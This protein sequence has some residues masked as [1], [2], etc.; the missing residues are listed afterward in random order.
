[1]KTASRA[2]WT[3]VAF[4]TLCPSVLTAET[5]DIS[6]SDDATQLTIGAHGAADG[7]T[8]SRSDIVA[9]AD[10]AELEGGPAFNTQVRVGLDLNLR[11]DVGKL[12]II[13]YTA[14]GADVFSGYVQDNSSIEGIDL[15]G[16]ETHK[17]VVREAFARVSIGPI[18]TVGGG[19]MT[20]QWGLGLL[21]NSGEE[22]WKPGSA[23]FVDPRGGDV[24]L[25][26]LLATGPWTDARLTVYGFADR[27]R[28]DRSLRPGDEATQFGGGARLGGED[29]NVGIYFVRREVTALD[30]DELNVNAIDVAGGYLI[31]LDETH[32]LELEGEVALISGKADFGPNVDFPTHDV[33][34]LGGAVR[35]TFA[36]SGWGAVLDAIWA[37]GD[38]NLDDAQINNFRADPNY[39]MGLLLFREVMATQSG[40]APV[41]ASNPE[42]VG[43]PADDLDRLPTQG[44]VTNTLAFF[45]R[46]Y[47]QPL[48]G[49]ELYG[50]PLFAFADSAVVDPLNTRLNG[51]EPHNALG[52]TGGRFLGTELD[53]GARAHLD[54]PR[55]QMLSAGIEAAVLLPGNA[56]RDAAGDLMDPVFGGRAMARYQF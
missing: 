19:I 44:S 50:G 23:A 31:E 39:E 30:G 52:G 16:S 36:A 48:K 6:S 17:N 45:P 54:L 26:G 3:T 32:D 41:T 20:S 34:Q 13:V 46:A 43:E 56:F 47:W 18:I 1:M 9:D 22:T 5:Y 33:L 27:V 51:G 14:V 4:I 42:L 11:Q 38:Q 40:R 37:S 8:E 35:G 7:R 2:W 28:E 53:L 12:P 10:G 29:K 49:F 24:V 25:R 55:E 21:A 15:P